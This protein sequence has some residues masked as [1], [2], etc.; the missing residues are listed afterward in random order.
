MGRGRFVGGSGP[1]AARLVRMVNVSFTGV[2]GYMTD[3]FP[4]GGA[5]GG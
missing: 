4:H 1:E 3:P 2:F 5:L